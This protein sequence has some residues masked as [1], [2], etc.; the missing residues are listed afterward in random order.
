MKQLRTISIWALALVFMSMSECGNKQLTDNPPFTVGDSYSQEWVAG[1]ESG[2]SGVNLI[3]QITDLQE[4]VSID[5]VYFRG[6]KVDLATKPGD[7]ST[8]AA[9]LLH[10][11]KP[12]MTMSGDATAEYGN[13][14]PKMGEEYNLGPDACVIVYTHNGKKGYTKVEGI[15]RKEA[16][17]YPSAP[18]PDGGY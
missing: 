14:V 11:P 9:Y 5:S 3:V 1:V 7:D 17:A 12:D 10:P 18:N 16:Q 6:Q 4:G 2:G 13:P 15:M 8:Y